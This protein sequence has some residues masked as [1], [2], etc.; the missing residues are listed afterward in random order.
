MYFFQLLLL[1]LLL[2]L[3]LDLPGGEAYTRWVITKACTL[4]VE[5]S[6]NVNKFSCVIT[7]NFRPDTL[8]MNRF[9]GSEI[10]NINGRMNL[11]IQDFDCHNPLM[12]GDL[13]KT[14]KAKEFPKMIIRFISLGRYP[15][16][17]LKA[18]PINGI[19][20]IEIAGVSKKYNVA[21]MVYHSGKNKMALR[22]VREIKFSDFGI[23][24]PSKIGGMVKTNDKLFAEFNL[25]L[26][27]LND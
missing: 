1:P 12:T 9:K 24:P 25:A 22:G 26:Q 16:G 7:G 18:Y 2:L 11:Y 21:Y 3:K 14:L 17:E 15:D 5:G 4:K 23:V 8:T 20:S 27:L 10:T 19:V 13:R 6:T